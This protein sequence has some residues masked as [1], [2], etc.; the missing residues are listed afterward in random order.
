MQ[1]DWK[2]TFPQQKNM[3]PRRKCFL[4]CLKGFFMLHLIDVQARNLFDNWCL[5]C[6]KSNSKLV[7][8]R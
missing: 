7:L 6:D 2:E 1:L 8:V 4:F 3:I 5:D